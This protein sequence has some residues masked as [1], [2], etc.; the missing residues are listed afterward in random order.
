MLG[1]SWMGVVFPS[2]AVMD[3]MRRPAL[4]VLLASK[5]SY[6]ICARPLHPGLGWDHSRPLGAGAA[7]DRYLLG[8]PAVGP[9]ISA[10]APHGEIRSGLPTGTG[11]RGD[12]KR[13]EAVADHARHSLSVICRR[14]RLG[15]RQIAPDGKA[16]ERG[17]GCFKAVL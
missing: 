16:T 17:T 2:R 8:R 4:L 7:P 14:Y 6:S 9:G 5:R 15:G 13:H 3:V 1:D 12:A 11:D 10:E